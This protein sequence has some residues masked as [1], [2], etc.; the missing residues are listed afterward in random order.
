M[1]S[2]SP[3]Q[4]GFQAQQTQVALFETSGEAD[5]QLGPPVG[6][7]TEENN[8]TSNARRALIEQIKGI[9]KRPAVSVHGPEQVDSLGSFGSGVA[10]ASTGGG[11]R[12]ANVAQVKTVP[13]LPFMAESFEPIQRKNP[14][15]V[16]TINV[17]SMWDA[18]EDSLTRT[19]AAMKDILSQMAGAP[20]VIEDTFQARGQRGP[21]QSNRQL[22]MEAKKQALKQWWDEQQLLGEFRPQAPQIA[23][24]PGLTKPEPIPQRPLRAQGAGHHEPP[25]PPL[26]EPSL[27][28]DTEFALQREQQ[29]RQAAAAAAAWRGQGTVPTDIVGFARSEGQLPGYIHE[30]QRMQQR[31]LAQHGQ[32]VQRWQDPMASIGAIPANARAAATAGGPQAGRQRPH[33][34]QPPKHMA[35]HQHW[36]EGNLP[37]LLPEGASQYPNQWPQQQH[38]PTQVSSPSARQGGYAPPPRAAP[39]LDADE[40]RARTAG[41]LPDMHGG[42]GLHHGGQQM[43]WAVGGFGDVAGAAPCTGSDAQMMQQNRHHGG[44]GRGSGV[45][46]R[47]QGGGGSCGGGGASASASG[48]W[49][50][51]SMCEYRV[52]SVGDLPLYDNRRPPARQQQAAP[53][54]QAATRGATR[55]AASQARTLDALPKMEEERSSKPAGRARAGKKDPGPPL[56]QP[57]PPGLVTGPPPSATS[58]P[59]TS[60]IQG[61]ATSASAAAGASPCSATAGVASSPKKDAE[62]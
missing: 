14:A 13:D 29:Q 8:G 42:G 20:P 55:G 11:D 51:T 10:S 33:P 9:L 38:Q 59:P 43:H 21:S 41:D 57:L 50:S 3:A 12:V 40:L 23:P 16:E 6:V 32:A 45:A 1:T 60:P 22:M 36:S 35:H 7:A 44:V 26:H 4:I 56:P 37:E 62:A 47:A 49:R 39:G 28:P 52:R 2:P 46:P 24:P 25:P 19:R 31:P 58:G 18:E 5:F 54:R 61:E 30:P 27:G 15:Q 17:P 53:P 34:H 48:S